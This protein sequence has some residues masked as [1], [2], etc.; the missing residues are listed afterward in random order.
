MPL[1]PHLGRSQFLALAVS[2]TLATAGGELVCRSWLPSP[3]FVPRDPNY[4]RGLYLTHPERG[5]A[6]ARNF[7]GRV[8]TPDFDVHFATDEKGLRTGDRVEEAASEGEQAEKILAVGDSFAAGWGVEYEQ[9]W[10]MRLETRWNTRDS[11]RIKLIN[12]GIA[13][14]SLRQIR[15]LAEELL[16][17]GHPDSVVLEVHPWGYLRIEDPYVLLDGQLFQASTVSR[18]RVA[19]GGFSYTPFQADSLRNLD[20]WLCSR[21][22]MGAR[23][24]R[25]SHWT[26]SSLA[27]LVKQI[28][29]RGEAALHE[30]VR[31]EIDP[32][33]QEIA[34]MRELTAGK[35]IPLVVLLANTQSRDGSFTRE[36]KRMNAVILEFCREQEIAVF[37][38]LP[39]LEQRAG[40]DPVFRFPGDGHWNAGAHRVVAEG[41]TDFL[42]RMGW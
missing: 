41:L 38:P 37:D 28:D 8:V 17:E 36:E 12:A 6:Y 31:R 33:L 16:A 34:G 27:A 21:F 32:L 40:D 30:A 19:S 15:M 3:D 5:F 35:R 14:Y 2:I 13:G 22:W 18:V 1:G 29:F 20:A 42:V 23:L 11:G 24:L 7:D 39:L 10:P 26:A 25:L 9:A 4:V